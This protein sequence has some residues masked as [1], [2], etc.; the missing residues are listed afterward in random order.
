M[1]IMTFSVGRD[2][3]TRHKLVHHKKKN[4]L[5]HHHRHHLHR[6]TITIS[7]NIIKNNN[8]A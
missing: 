3:G 5:G 8:K 4:G 7:T 6:R 1:F 2:R